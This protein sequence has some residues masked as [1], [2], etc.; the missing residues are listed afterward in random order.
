MKKLINW[1]FAKPNKQEV[2]QLQEVIQPEF[3]FESW[4]VKA[5]RYDNVIKAEN[6]MTRYIQRG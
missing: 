6:A 4:E 2:I 5:K 1:I 3:V